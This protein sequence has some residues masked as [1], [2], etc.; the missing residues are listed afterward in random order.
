M[1]TTELA[2]VL[3]Q[4]PSTVSGHLAVLH[5]TGLLTNWR[6]GRAVFY[7]RTALAKLVLSASDRQPQPASDGVGRRGSPEANVSPRAVR[8]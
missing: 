3:G 1:T 8:W 6:S 4:S 2:H 7:Q 5:G